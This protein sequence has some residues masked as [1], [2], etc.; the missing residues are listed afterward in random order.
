MHIYTP[1]RLQKNVFGSHW[2]LKNTLEGVKMSFF[3][4]ST[5]FMKFL[6][7]QKS[8][9]FYIF[10]THTGLSWPKKMFFLFTGGSKKH[11]KA[12]KYVF[13]IFQ[14]QQIFIKFHENFD[15]NQKNTFYAF[16]CFPELPV[17]FKNVFLEQVWA[18]NVQKIYWKPF[19][20]PRQGF[21]TKKSI[22]VIFSIFSSSTNYTSFNLNLV[23]GDRFSS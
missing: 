9:F 18:I 11:W 13:I 15:K 20:V 22:F 14:K 19:Q 12:W 6:Q 23:R 1:N 2:K 17:W 16:Q 10:F 5:F 21:L 8:H 3:D 7:Y 4:F